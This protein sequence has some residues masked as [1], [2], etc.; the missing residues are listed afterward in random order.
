MGRTDDD[1]V[2]TAG[3]YRRSVPLPD[4]LRT[5]HGRSAR[6]VD[7]ELHVVYTEG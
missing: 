4:G 1:L 5:W 3:T 2:V 7:D 6:R